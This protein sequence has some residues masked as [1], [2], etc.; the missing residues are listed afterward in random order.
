MLK[1]QKIFFS[2]HEHIFLIGQQ[3]L[4]IGKLTTPTKMFW[5]SSRNMKIFL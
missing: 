2:H 5:Y 4:K 1:N 3:Q